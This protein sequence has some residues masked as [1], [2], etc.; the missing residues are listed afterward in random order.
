MHLVAVGEVGEGFHCILALQPFCVHT[1]QHQAVVVRRLR[2][3]AQAS[4]QLCLRMD[5]VL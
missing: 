4:V 3:L 2:P 1:F 5:G